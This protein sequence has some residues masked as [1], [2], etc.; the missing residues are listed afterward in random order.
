MSNNEL[1]EKGLKRYVEIYEATCG[2]QCWSC[3]RIDCGYGKFDLI[4]LDVYEVT[5]RKL[6]LNNIDECLIEKRERNK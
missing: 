1:I 5:C 6:K 3:N 4:E 2:E